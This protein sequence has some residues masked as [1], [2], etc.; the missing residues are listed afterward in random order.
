MAIL[1]SAKTGTLT[2]NELSLR[3][4]IIIGDL[5]P[6]LFLFYAALA[7]KR[8]V[9]NQDAI[10]S[11]ITAAVPKDDRARFREFEELDFMP[12]NPTDKR[13][14]VTLRG[15]DGKRFKI[16]K[17]APQYIL[18]LAHKCVARARVSRAPQL[19]CAH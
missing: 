2:L 8:E 18:R 12:F 7:S 10:D 13:T 17:G 6:G 19:P 15:P 14:E 16:T 5:T 9:G 11:C 1:C 3:E 4:P